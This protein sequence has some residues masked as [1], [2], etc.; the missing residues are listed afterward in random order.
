MS[1]SS[2]SYISRR[3]KCLHLYNAIL[4]EF[5]EVSPVITKCV[6]QKLHPIIEQIVQEYIV[7]T[8]Y[9]QQ[10]IGIAMLPSIIRETFL[11]KENEENE[12][13]DDN[14]QIMLRLNPT[15]TQKNRLQM[16]A[17][18]ECEKPRITQCV[19]IIMMMLIEEAESL[20]K[21]K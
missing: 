17:W 20:I 21:M 14:C 2:T 10:R 19:Q 13:N 18:I 5:Q 9:L 1:S 3:Q 4:Y 11:F 15:M 16:L 6:W 7:E 12:E 8:T